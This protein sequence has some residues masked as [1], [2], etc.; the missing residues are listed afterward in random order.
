M[1]KTISDKVLW[2][3]GK[4][5]KSFMSTRR[6]LKLI[7]IHFI[8]KSA[9]MHLSICAKM[10]KV[11]KPYRLQIALKSNWMTSMLMIALKSDFRSWP[12]IC[13]YL[14]LEVLTSMHILHCSFKWL[15][16]LRAVSSPIDSCTILCDFP[17]EWNILPICSPDC[18]VNCNVT[19]VVKTWNC[20]DPCACLWSYRCSSY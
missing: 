4:H 10:H 12:D 6:N 19:R 18:C 3:M 15:K 20:C 7:K 9:A 5:H 8:S 2:S 13:S 16:E 11:Y 14:R 17:L 1:W